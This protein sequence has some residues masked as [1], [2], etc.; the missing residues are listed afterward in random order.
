MAWNV[1]DT[2]Y[3]LHPLLM[4]CIGNSREVCPGN[5]KEM[6]GKSGCE[7]HDRDEQ[8]LGELRCWVLKVL[9]AGVSWFSGSC[10]ILSCE[11]RICEWLGHCSLF[12]TP[13][14][15]VSLPPA[16]CKA[17]RPFAEVC[18]CCLL[19]KPYKLQS[20]PESSCWYL[21]CSRPQLNSH[22]ISLG[23]KSSCLL[24]WGLFCSGKGLHYSDDERNEPTSVSSGL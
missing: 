1:K 8:K 23:C 13:C 19:A 10:G 16:L 7:K 9:W 21:S 20:K 22:C 2:K 4:T 18:W 5:P 14:G 24:A 11:D 6:F 15:P 3:L 12:R 17:P